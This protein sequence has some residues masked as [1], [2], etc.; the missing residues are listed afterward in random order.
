LDGWL[1][2]DFRGMNPVAGTLLGL[3]ALT[4]RYFVLVRAQGT[5][6][7]L[8]HRIEQQPWA[9]WHGEKRVYSSW[10]EMEAELAS[11]LGG[12]RRLAMEYTP[13]D[14]V[15]VVDRV[16]AGIVELVRA[17]G[18]EPEGSGDLISFFTARWSDEG[19]ASHRRASAAV[20][21]TA[22]AAFERI[23][24]AV[25]AGERTTEWEVRHW[26]QG[27]L[28][29]RGIN[30]GGDGIVAVNANAANAHYAPSAEQHAEIRAGDLVLI[31]LWGKENDGAIYAD[32]T[33]M[34]FVGDTIPERLERMFGTLVD[35]REAAC[36]M[37]I[38]RFA[39]GNAVSGYEVDDVARGII[40]ARGYGEQI[41]HR[42]GHSIDRELH[43]SG[44]N[45]DNMET[46]DTRTLIPGVGF[47]V[48]PGIYF[49]GDV[50]FRSE[51]NMF[52]GAAGPEVT[53]DRPQRRLYALLTDDPFAG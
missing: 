22:H 15:P 50:G 24:A 18:A 28:V 31:D 41:I 53:T 11:I 10:R 38:D 20:R 21:D 9:T 14:A 52:I 26:I 29:R 8:T 45:I 13:G 23:A 47:S 1:L 42:T 19:E 7:A 4:R 27:E 33:W 12:V 25:R 32:Q 37:V 40:E 6:V 49:P 16:P 36:Q 17:A 2:Y 39:A 30:V 44:P 34:A 5:P 3:P 51:V 48:E 35:A 46:R 43:G